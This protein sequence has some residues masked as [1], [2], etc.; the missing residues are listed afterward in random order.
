[1]AREKKSL[2][3]QQ[4]TD[5]DFLTEKR[6]LDLVL[7]SFLPGHK[8]LLAAVIGKEDGAGFKSAEVIETDLLAVD[9]RQ[10]K[11][12]GVRC[13]KLLLKVEGETFPARPVAVQESDCRIEAVRGERAGGVETQ[14][15]VEIGKKGVERIERRAAVAVAE[16]EGVSLLGDEEIGVVLDNHIAPEQGKDLAEDSGV[17]FDDAGERQY[18]DNAFEAVANGVVECEGEGG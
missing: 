5:G 11:A 14:E 15:R 12:V 8:D 13:A 3:V 1:M 2:S 18:V 6:M 7:F 10:G 9:E 4:Q 17:L 16:R